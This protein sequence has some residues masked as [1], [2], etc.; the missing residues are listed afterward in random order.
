MKKLLPLSS[1]KLKI[2]AVS[3]LLIICCSLLHSQNL[4]PNPNFEQYDTCPNGLNEMSRCMYWKAF[5]ASP[6]YFNECSSTYLMAPPNAA[7]GFQYPHS[8]NAYAS[9]A[10]YNWDHIGHPNYREHLGVQLISPLVIG[11]KYYISFFISTCYTRQYSNIAT[12]KIGA[13]V[14]TYQYSLPESTTYAL[15]NACTI[16]EDSIITDSINWVKISGSFVADSAY[17]FLV[18]G[19]FYDDNHIDTLHLPY[20]NFSQSGGYYVDDV[21]LSTDS[22]Y[23]ETWTSIKEI[24]HEDNKITFYPNPCSDEVRIKAKETIEI[25]QIINTTGQIIYSSDKPENL[26]IILP[27]DFLKQGLYYLKIKTITGLYFSK[28]N[29][30][31]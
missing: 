4:V 26:E 12:N 3:F 19:N 6:D 9:F 28:I 2:I 29:I 14:T 17:K 1:I 21:C 20:N 15:P 16:E 31:H 30:L 7:W 25:I 13:L 18:I 24:K 5:R 10:T 22:I 23:C 27:V 11:T 8:G